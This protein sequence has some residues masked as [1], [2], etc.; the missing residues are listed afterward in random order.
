MLSWLAITYNSARLGL[1]AQNAAALRL[2][3]WVG[4]ASKAGR[5]IAEEI[6]LPVDSPAARAVAPKQHPA[7]KT[8]RLH[9]AKKNHKNSAPVRKRS[10][11]VKRG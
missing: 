1:E 6:A 2:L 11:R 8:K 10:K 3:R 5:G 7:A 9:A 4:D